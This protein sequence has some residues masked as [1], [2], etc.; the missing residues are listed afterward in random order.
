MQGFQLSG[1]EYGQFRH[2][3][4]LPD[5]QL[6]AQGA[7]RRIAT[8]SPGFPCRVSLQDAEVG[9]ELIL[10]PYLHQ[11]TVSPYRASG[12]IFVRRNAKQKTL[13]IGEVPTYVTRRQISVRAYDSADMM[14][15]ATVCDGSEA[16]REIEQFFESPDVGYIHLHNAKQGCFSCSVQRA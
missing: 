6:R 9:E 10:L 1:I 16:G 13:E 4:M 15:G 14:I 3:F 11:D 5:D 7:I 12:P 2:L 8:E